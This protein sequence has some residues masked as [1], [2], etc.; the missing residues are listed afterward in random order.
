MRDSQPRHRS[1]LPVLTPRQQVVLKLIARG[2]TNSEIARA[3]DISLEGAKYHVREIMARLEV[4]SREEAAELWRANRA[5]RS[6][7]ARRVRALLSLRWPVAVAATLAAAGGVVATAIILGDGSDPPASSEPA[8]SVPTATPTATATPVVP[9]P[10]PPPFGPYPLGTRTGDP[11]I[12]AV[13]AAVESAG[14][15]ALFELIHYTPVP[16][17]NPTTG[18]LQ[19]PGTFQCPNGEPDGTGI[20]SVMGEGSH[21]LV[22]P[23]GDASIP[24][25]IDSFLRPSAPLDPRAYAI[26]A[27]GPDLGPGQRTVVFASGQALVVDGQGIVAFLAVTTLPEN[28]VANAAS[29]LLPPLPQDPA[30]FATDLRNE[31]FA[32]AA[33]ATLTDDSAGGFGLFAAWEAAVPNLDIAPAGDVAAGR[34]VSALASPIDPPPTSPTAPRH[35]VHIAVSDDAGNCAAGFIAVTLIPGHPRGG[36]VTFST[37]ALP[38]GVPCTAEAAASTH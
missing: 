33:T 4:G 2:R 11:V 30:V 22:L 16:C 1:G 6:S 5:I 36:I 35:G 10:T 28:R 13:L 17:D 19:P 12:D 3:L 31:L 7:T 18:Q 14:A 8:T 27:E 32:A 15:D 9:A 21:G 26:V 34:S 38:A 25:L 23:E 24:Q 37:I 20:P 29:F